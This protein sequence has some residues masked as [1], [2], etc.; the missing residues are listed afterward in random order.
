MSNAISTFINAFQGGTRP[1]RFSITG[2]RP[3]GVESPAGGSSNLFIDTHCLAANLPESTVGII[4]IPFRG[5][6]YKFPGDRQYS[7]WTATILDDTGAKSTW[8]MFHDWS[9]LFNSHELNIANDN[10]HISNFCADLTISQLDH[11]S[12]LAGG[13]QGPPSPNAGTLKTIQLVNAWPVVVGPVVLDMASANT[14]TQF[15]VTIAYSH[16]I[17]KQ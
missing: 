2:T 15:Q 1:N 6:I 12:G 14:L 7:E 11:G 16:Y 13:A 17:V 9:E 5:R 3:A 8:K 4:P 10:K